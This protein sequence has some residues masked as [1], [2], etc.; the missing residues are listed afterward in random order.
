MIHSYAGVRCKLVGP[1]A[2]KSGDFVIQ[3][4]KRVPGFINLMGIESPGLTA[5]PAIAERVLDILADSMN[6][7]VKKN[8]KKRES[9]PRFSR[10][11]P[12]EKDRLIS[13][14]PR[15]GH[16]ICRCEHVTEQEIIDALGNPLDV[17]TL[18]GIKYRSRAM[19]GRCQGGFCKARIIGIME[20]SLDMNYDDITLRGPGSHLFIGKT[21][22]L[23]KHEKK[24]R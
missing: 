23:R 11:K 15:H 7:K 21:K 4:E 14:K 17:R 6:L 16:L 18:A 12:R 5:S 13:E 24:E 10:M 20:G 8:F 9:S 22:D 19:M 1:R 3:E 2:R